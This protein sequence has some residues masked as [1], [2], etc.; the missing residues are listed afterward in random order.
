MVG[1]LLR[2]VPTPIREFAVRRTTPSY[3]MGAM[4]R[5]ERE[6]GRRVAREAE[7]PHR[8]DAARRCV[9]ARRDPDRLHAARVARRDRPA[10][11]GRRRTGGDGRPEAP[12]L[13]L[14]LPGP[15]RSRRAVP[16]MRVRCRSRSPR[17]A[18]SR[19][20]DIPADQRPV[21]HARCSRSTLLPT[22]SGSWSSN[23]T[24]LQTAGGGTGDSVTQPPEGSMRALS[25]VG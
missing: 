23:P 8:V 24:N 19:P 25:S 13:R 10:L 12:H 5:V 1:R 15:T 20:R 14:R 17:S 3:V 7:L 21:R 4:C 9:R 16:R 22:A 2:A 11:R 18:G 6:D